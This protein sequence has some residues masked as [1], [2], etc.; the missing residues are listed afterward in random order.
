[1][2]PSQAL[3]GVSTNSATNGG[4][5]QNNPIGFSIYVVSKGNDDVSSLV[6]SQQFL[7]QG[8]PS[9]VFTPY[10]ELGWKVFYAP[11]TVVERLV[12]Q[13]SPYHRQV[14]SRSE[15][16][17]IPTNNNSNNKQGQPQ[18]HYQ[19]QDRFEQLQ[20]H[21]SS[22]G[23]QPT[24]VQ[25]APHNRQMMYHRSNSAAAVTPSTMRVSPEFHKS[26][27]VFRSNSGGRGII[28]SAAA[29]A[30]SVASH[31]SPQPQRQKLLRPASADSP[32]TP[33]TA[34][35]DTNG[36][37]G[38]TRALSGLSLAMMM[39]DENVDVSPDDA[40]DDNNN[41]EDPSSVA[42]TNDQAEKRRAALHHAP[43]NYNSS[44]NA[45]ALAASPV[46]KK[47]SL[48]IA[49]EYGYAYNS[50]IPIVRTSSSNNNRMSPID[51]NGTLAD[52][53]AS[54]S[55]SLQAG[56]PP[57]GAGFL[58]GATPPK[59]GGFLGGVGPGG[60]NPSSLIPPRSAVTP[61][62]VRPAGFLTPSEPAPNQQLP[63][64]A[65]GGSAATPYTTTSGT[66]I[67]TNNVTSAAGN[68]SF[69][70]TPA[71]AGGDVTGTGHPVTSL[72]LLH[73]SPFQQPPNAS[74]LSSLSVPQDPNN[75]MNSVL[76]GDFR[77]QAAAEAAYGS[78]TAADNPFHT[79]SHHHYYPP[80]S[81]DLQD[82]MPFAVDSSPPF[83]SSGM[84]GDGSGVAASTATAFSGSHLAS[85]QA[86]ASFAQ[87]CATASRLAL[88][89][90]L[91][92]Q[93][94]SVADEGGLSK[95]IESAMSQPP[96]D[97]VASLADQL[98]EFKSFGASLQ[99]SGTNPPT[100]TRFP[101]ESPAGPIDPM[102]NSNST[103][104]SLR[105]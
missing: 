37:G 4:G 86:V 80:S 63:P 15:S 65:D 70:A 18:E 100:G 49:G 27:T 21:N 6:S 50:H 43:P 56:T 24:S 5:G 101:P 77:L 44:N 42:A 39:S 45:D 83:S 12:P 8:Q 66:S 72:D 96:S 87:R 51:Q 57:T 105:T 102:S 40:T 9:S 1:M 69:P 52:R 84:P 88:F 103:P 94:H 28:M 98:A 54:P 19:Q 76:S 29:A 99:A 16:R 68:G 81:L 58:M 93:Q 35:G 48:A 62:F 97:M 20:R 55:P 74:L 38:P 22:P 61:P 30:A 89:D 82:E 17:P 31:L 79:A 59:V 71:G 92:Q 60:A 85:S 32:T 64:P 34:D 3:R 26:P 7:A 91:A 11:K 104:I 2:L 23:A 90:S 13:P 36:E 33:A 53:T 41:N 75:Y 73:S 78:T 67:H 25:S 10:G 47:S 95:G 14:T 46:L